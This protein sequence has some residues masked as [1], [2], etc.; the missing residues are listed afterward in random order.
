[1]EDCVGPRGP[2]GIE[3]VSAMMWAVSS[4]R[5]TRVIDTTV[6]QRHGRPQHIG[7]MQQL[8]LLMNRW[9]DGMAD[10][11][12]SY[13]AHN[14]LDGWRRLCHQ[15]PPDTKHGRQLLMQDFNNLKAAKDVTEP[16]DR[17]QEMERITSLCTELADPD[18][19]GGQELGKLKTIIPTYVYN[20]IATVARGSKHYG[21]LVQIAEEQLMD[22]L[23]GLARG[24]KQPGVSV[25]STDGN[26]N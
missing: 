21:A 12:T 3:F 5:A 18:Y 13:D 26:G 8:Q 9:A 2:D 16:R 23:M 10:K 11:T 4:G 20:S 14:G 22:H 25:P 6:E 19:D 1:M 7:D 17:M 24:D 15:Q